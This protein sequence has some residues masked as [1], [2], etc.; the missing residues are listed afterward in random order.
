MLDAWVKKQ[1]KLLNVV[2]ATGNTHP[3]ATL[4][5]GAIEKIALLIDPKHRTRHSEAWV[6]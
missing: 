6:E 2:D 1:E 4:D 3:I 5:I